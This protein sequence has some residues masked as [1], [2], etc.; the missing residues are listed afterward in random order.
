MLLAL[1]FT[2]VPSGNNRVKNLPLGVLIVFISFAED[3]ATW[4]SPPFI[5]KDVDFLPPVVMLDWLSAE[6]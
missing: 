4:M 5:Y 1:S 2:T 3:L 6:A